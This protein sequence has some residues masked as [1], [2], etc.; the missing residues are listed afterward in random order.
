M[1]NYVS[2][3][4]EKKQNGLGTIFGTSLNSVHKKELITNLHWDIYAVQQDT[5]S[6]F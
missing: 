3:N 4:K 5:Q 2:L 6:D 1:T